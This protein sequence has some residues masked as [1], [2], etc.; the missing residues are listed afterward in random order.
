MRCATCGC[1][2]DPT[3]YYLC[4]ALP[5]S[6]AVECDGCTEQPQPA[7]PDEKEE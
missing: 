6:V 3:G 7:P 2:I 5:G 4:G 1:Y